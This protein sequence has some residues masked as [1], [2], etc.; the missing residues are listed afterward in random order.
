MRLLDTGKK[1]KKKEDMACFDGISQ[2]KCALGLYEWR[3]HIIHELAEACLAILFC[4][5]C[6]EV[7]I[8]STPWHQK[9]DL[10]HSF[11]QSR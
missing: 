7:N 11:L 6:E 2:N 4:V 10:T 9:G 8:Q 5:I 3:V 1:K